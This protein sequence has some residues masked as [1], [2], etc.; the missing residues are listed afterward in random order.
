MKRQCKDCLKSERIL[1]K[2]EYGD[3]Y[4]CTKCGTWI[5]YCDVGYVSAWDIVCRPPRAVDKVEAWEPYDPWIV[6]HALQARE[7]ISRQGLELHMSTTLPLKFSPIRE[8][9][10]PAKAIKILRGVPVSLP[11][12]GRKGGDC[13]GMTVTV[14][15]AGTLGRQGQFYVCTTR[16]DESD[17]WF[18][19]ESMAYKDVVAF[20]LEGAIFLGRSVIRMGANG[21]MLLSTSSSLMMRIKFRAVK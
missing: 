4:V 6:A 1:Q 10:T 11:G 3:R 14:G 7:E 13:K 8:L 12:E 18:S 2:S 5:P 15:E 9:F 20:Q 19:S 21:A 17:I 16:G